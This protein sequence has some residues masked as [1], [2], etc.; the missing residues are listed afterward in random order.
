MKFVAMPTG[1]WHLGRGDGN[2]AKCSFWLST[3][4]VFSMLAILVA[5]MLPFAEQTVA[6]TT[7]DKVVVK[8]AARV[9]P[10][11]LVATLL[12]VL[13]SLCTSGVFSGQGRQVLVTVLSFF[14]DIPLSIGGVA[15]IVLLFHADLLDVY[16]YGVCAALL[17]LAIAYGFIF[18]SNW[19]QC[20]EDAQAR[21]LAR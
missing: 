13:N 8:N 9:L 15:V 11:A 14:V 18:A 5:I 6:L 12:G 2:A 7:S 20:A 17:E 1:P 21:Q 16:L 19:K 3:G 4:I 10:A